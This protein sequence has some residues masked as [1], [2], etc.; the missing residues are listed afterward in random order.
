MRHVQKC[1]TLSL[2]F[3]H[4]RTADRISRLNTKARCQCDSRLRSLC[5]ENLR[6]LGVAVVI[7]VGVAVVVGVVAASA[8]ALFG[9]ER[10]GTCEAQRCGAAAAGC[11]PAT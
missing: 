8:G 4:L 7:V 9:G 11:S 10:A 6:G 3:C 5:K 1:S 2:S